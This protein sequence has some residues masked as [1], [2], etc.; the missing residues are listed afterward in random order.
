VTRFQYSKYYFS[1]KAFSLKAFRPPYFNYDSLKA[2]R[3]EQSVINEDGPHAFSVERC[4]LTALTRFILNLEMLHV[5]PHIQ[6]KSTGALH[7]T[8]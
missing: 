8:K 7:Q 2:F 6:M 3:L 5:L 1:L 4:L